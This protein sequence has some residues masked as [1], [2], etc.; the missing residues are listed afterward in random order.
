M[1]TTLQENKESKAV[2]NMILKL[3][4]AFAKNLDSEDD[5]EDIEEDEIDIDPILEQT[6]IRSFDAMLEE[7][8]YDVEVAV[9]RFEAQFKR[10]FVL[11]YKA[12]NTV[13]EMD[14]V[15]PLLTDSERDEYNAVMAVI[16][17]AMLNPKSLQISEVEPEDIKQA[18][19][20]YNNALVEFYSILREG[21]Q[22]RV[23]EMNAVVDAPR[24]RPRPAF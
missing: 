19:L 22:E 21:L 10:L 12:M 14:K 16:M 23:N 17:Q 9:G 15:N 7:S 5:F 2:I 1:T 6:L 18:F 8:N 3:I 11:I 13:R 20:T 24:V 4:N